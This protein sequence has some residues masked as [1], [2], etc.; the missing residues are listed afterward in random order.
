MSI[1]N[2]EVI[3]RE[4]VAGVGKVGDAVKV[5]AGHA[6]NFLIPQ[7][8][9]IL[10][11]EQNKQQFEKERVE[12]E[13]KAAEQRKTAEEQ[14]KSVEKLVLEHTV[15]T[16]AD[17]KLFGSVTVRDV[18]AILEAKEINVSKQ[19]IKLVGGNIHHAGD[20]QVELTFYADV[21]ALVDLK[22]ISNHP[23]YKPEAE[24]EQVAS[25]EEVAPLAQ[26]GT[27]TSEDVAPEESSLVSEA[28]SKPE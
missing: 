7:S 18:I 23:E 17:G 2:V 15:K 4:S 13:K 20:Y 19:N 24:L 28:D 21:V 26:E 5:K 25:E 3:L 8:K 11:T 22:I 6:F 27:E 16:S 10:M 12:L 1:N 14:A 9:A